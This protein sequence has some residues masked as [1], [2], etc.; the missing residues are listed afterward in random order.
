MPYFSVIVPVY[1]VEQYLE[2]CVE[3]V[4]SQ[5][6]TDFELILV[7]D[8]SPDKSPVLCDEYAK[9]YPQVHAFHKQNGGAASAR[10]A[11]IC[12][13]TGEYV[14]FLDSDDYW[15]DPTALQKLQDKLI[16]EQRDVCIYGCKDFLQA[17]GKIVLSRG[18]YDENVFRAGTKDEILRS[19][20]TSGQFPGS[21]WIVTVKRKLFDE[22]KLYFQE[23]NRAEDIDWLL[24]VFSN[25]ESFSCLNNNFYVYRKN[26]SDSVTGT[27][28]L[29]SLKGILATVDIWSVRLRLEQRYEVYQSLNTY[30]AFVF[31]TAVIIY[32]DLSREDKAEVRPLFR[33]SRVNL[34]NILDRKTR[35]ACNI[36]R[37]AGLRAAS[38]MLHLFRRF[39]ES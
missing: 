38:L 32:Y 16:L 8:G 34:K 6:F 36:Y 37:F 19:L 22:K 30:L 11:G 5:A 28:G 14:V 15:D 18:N 31:M 12:K 39:R 21:C 10:N 9:A 33:C 13:A 25:A 20:V 26:R 24:N 3:H 23:G 1:K 35:L 27:A 17:S 29:I 4:L 2:E 7:D